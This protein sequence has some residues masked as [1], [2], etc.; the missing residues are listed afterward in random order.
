[1]LFLLSCVDYNSQ[2]VLFPFLRIYAMDP[3]QRGAVVTSVD[4]RTR[5]Q[6]KAWRGHSNVD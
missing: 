6:H 3:T 5:D 2:L 1:M 4:E